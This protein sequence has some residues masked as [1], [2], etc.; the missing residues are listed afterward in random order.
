MTKSLLWQTLI[1]I[2]TLNKETIKDNE[3]E[4]RINPVVVMFGDE[5]PFQ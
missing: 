5:T 3:D 2:K 4:K 1:L